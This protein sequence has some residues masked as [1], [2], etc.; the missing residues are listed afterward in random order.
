MTIR[1][2]R[3]SAVQAPHF[4]IDQLHALQAEHAELQATLVELRRECRSLETRVSHLR[5]ALTRGEAERGGFSPPAEAV[6]LVDVRGLDATGYF[7]QLQLRERELAT[8]DREQQAI[9]TELERRAAQLH[10][11]RAVLA[12][13]TILLMHTRN[14]RFVA[15]AGLVQEL[16]H[17]AL[18]LIEREAEQG[19]ADA[20]RLD[21]AQQLW[22]L[23]NHLESRRTQ[24]TLREQAVQKAVASTEADLEPQRRLLTDREQALATVGSEWAALR[25]EELRRNRERLERRDAEATQLRLAATELDAKRTEVLAEAATVAAEA[26]AL[27]KLRRDLDPVAQRKLADMKAK[28]ERRFGKVR[29]EL[30][31]RRVTLDELTATAAENLRRTAVAEADQAA[32]ETDRAAADQSESHGRAQRL[33][34]VHERLAEIEGKL[35]DGAQAKREAEHLRDE[36]N[37]LTAMLESLPPPTLHEAAYGESLVPLRRAG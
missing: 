27:E 12:E 14:E 37:R 13:Q 18:Q 19:N 4:N 1:T 16:E 17:L 2:D 28:W 29:A 31:R 33:T 30:D 3:G 32:R 11:D 7:A 36:L 22:T 21:R 10:D 34:A 23:H 20:V 24:V 9:R 6:A 8:T 25:R 35:R 15:E 5:T 26:E